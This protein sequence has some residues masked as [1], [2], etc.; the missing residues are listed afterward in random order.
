ME[1]EIPSPPFLVKHSLELVSS[2]GAIGMLILA[3][4][5]PAVIVGSML[6]VSSILLGRYQRAATTRL[7]VDAAHDEVETHSSQQLALATTILDD[8]IHAL[9]HAFSIWERQIEHVR[10]DSQN[11]INSLSERFS[12]IV[13]KMDSAMDVFQA[14]ISRSANNDED[15]LSSFAHNADVQLHNV[16]SSLD[17]LLQDK[18]QVVEDVRE[19]TSFTE[20]LADMAQ[21]VGFIADQTNLLALNA[22]IEAARAGESGRGFAVVADEVRRLAGI[23]GETG[24]NIIETAKKIDGRINE[25]LRNV[26][27]KAEQETEI[28]S[29]ADEVINSVI[30]RYSNTNQHISIASNV[31]VQINTDIRNDVD[32]ALIALQFQD[33]VG[34]ILGNLKNN[35]NQ[36]EGSVALARDQVA[37]GHFTESVDTFEWL[38]AMKDEYTTADERQ[39]HDNG[40]VSDTPADD[41]DSGEVQFF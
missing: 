12:H 14:N 3:P 40:E 21:Q 25:T 22:A 17:V 30:E 26:E 7:I 38:E 29:K 2:A 32:Q 4:G 34:Q 33:R 19:L 27:T 31:L 36:V 18:H 13:A 5:I 11:E 23:S 20:E 41:A 9:V 24:Q 1:T 15:S 28:M 8:I 16:T 10:D 37:S 35:L 6:I 39:L